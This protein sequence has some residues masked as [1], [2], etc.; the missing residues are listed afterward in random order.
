MEARPELCCRS[1]FFRFTGTQSGEPRR[2]IGPARKRA[3]ND[4]FNGVGKPDGKG[5]SRKIHNAHQRGG[6]DTKTVGEGG[7][8]IIDRAERV[9]HLEG[10]ARP[11]LPGE[12]KVRAS[13][14]SFV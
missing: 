9:L 10:R 6:R 8:R 5:Q 7:S 11:L 2:Q 12:E 1:P 4:L 3:V 14:Q 13:G